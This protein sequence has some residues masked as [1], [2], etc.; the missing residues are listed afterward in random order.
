[1]GAR[2][3]TMGLGL[4]PRMVIFDGPAT[5]GLGSGVVRVGFG[6]TPVAWGGG[7]MAGPG[8]GETS[9]GEGRKRGFRLSKSSFF[10]ICRSMKSGASRVAA[11]FQARM[12]W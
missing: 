12:K 5:A 10:S 1:V 6:F 3:L 7:V 9:G 8:E 2:F 4:G 11:V